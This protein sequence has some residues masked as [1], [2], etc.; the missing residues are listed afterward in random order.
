MFD[1]FYTKYEDAKEFISEANAEDILKKLEKD[2]KSRK[3][4]AEKYAYLSKAYVF[5]HDNKKALKYA[6]DAIKADKNYAY[7]Y[8][9][10]AFAYAKEGKKKETLKYCKLA[11]TLHQDNFLNKTFLIVLYDYCD[12]KDYA[13][14]LFKELEDNND[15]SPAY[16]YNLGFV[17]IVIKDYERAEFY[18][19]KALESGYKDK[20]NLYAN[21]AECYSELQDVENANYFV[22][23]CL[24]IKETEDF[25]IKKS[26]C[27]V[28]EQ[29]YEEAKQILKNLYKTTEDKGWIITKLARL[30]D[31]ANQ[32]KK[33]LRY[34]NFALRI[35]G[36]EEYLYRRVAEFLERYRYYEKA[37]DVYKKLL[38]YN[39]KDAST[40]SSLSYCYSQLDDNE[41]AYN[42]VEQALKY[43]QSSYLYYRKARVLED[44][45]KY[46]EAIENF[47]KSLDYDETDTDCYQWIS[48]CY[49]VLKNYEKSLEYANRA[50]LLDKDDA[51]SYFRKAWALQEMKK[52]TEAIDFYKECIQRNDKY[53]DAYVNIS[54]IYSKLEDMKHSML[55]ANKALLINKDY[56]YAHYRKAWA[57]QESGQFEEALD[58]YSKAIELD[59]TDI[60]NYLGIACV[61]LNTQANINALLYANK[62]IMLDRNCGGAYY[63]KSLALS[64]LGKC[65]EAEKAYAQAVKLGYMPS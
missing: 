65:K 43:E 24:K 54:Y 53:I 7:G 20:Y 10:A 38:T 25:L 27:Y 35:T 15:N 22:D 9:R 28:F 8:I 34:Y 48:Y 56:A 52:Y 21:L 3:M 55:Y 49:S 23:E 62:A 14:E 13:Q 1:N 4:T 46:E 42:Y 18:Y 37:I 40:Y 39:K 47:I 59:P 6:K 60:Y 5:L 29:K 19:R 51:Y 61:S 50:I 26:D 11:E 32:P 12:E 44:E 36:E 63:Y 57:L 64:N 45:E 31:K 30:Y 2:K 16:L 58:G 41:N 33:A 17:Y